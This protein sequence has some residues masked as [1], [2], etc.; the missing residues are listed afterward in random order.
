MKPIISFLAGTTILL[1][2]VASAANDR[3]PAFDF[4]GTAIL[5]VSDADMVA[6][7][8]VDGQLGPREGTDALSVIA[9]GGDPRDWQAVEIEAPNSVAGPPAVID[10]TPDGQTAFV[11]ETFTQRPDNDDPHTFGDIG[12]GNRIS[13]FDL[14]DPA[15]PT[16]ER[17]V[18]TLT[19]PDALR[20]SSDGAWLAVTFNNEGAGSETPL[21]LYPIA[22]GDL[23]EPV[24]P[25]IPG[26][27]AGHRL[28][29]VDWHPDELLLAL[30]NETGADVRF[31]L[32][33]INDD[34]VSLEPYGNVVE[35]EKAQYR[36][37]F[38]PDG[39]NVIVNALY[40]GADVAGYWIE[41][42]DGSLLSI[43]LNAGEAADGTPRHALISRIATGVSPEGLAVSPD[44]RFALTTNL[45][46]S[47][48]PYDDPRITWYSSLT[49][50]AID[51]QTGALT[52]IGDYRYD[53]IL[54]EAAVFDASSRYVAVATFDQ[55]DDRRQGG[56]ID[57]WRITGDPLKPGE[58]TMIETD[59]AVP[60]TRGA[61][62]MVLIP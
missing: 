23:G 12:F 11:I 31:M 14:S 35:T 55:F 13:V 26:W 29:D 28:I 59:H 45:E 48:L 20:V 30:L 49:L 2:P 51:P 22:D 41:A 38:T 57:F 9:L 19:R 44:G 32:L 42:P 62:S 10:V 17:E 18:Q 36:V 7:A 52:K 61:H 47:Y 39:R 43:R 60:V 3:F 16:L 33:A 58:I 34:G 25:D 15:A 27:T 53:G 37:E 1:L 24:T 5:S 6:S 46:R 40:W 50:A 8:Y 21:A 4:Q 56:S 54:P